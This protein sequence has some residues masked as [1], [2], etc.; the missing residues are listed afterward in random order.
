MIRF[1][2]EI[3]IEASASTIWNVM[4][5]VE[6]WNEWTPT[7]TR[8]QKINGNGFVIGTRLLI[9]QPKLPKAIWKVVEVNPGAGF[10]M[11]KGNPFLQVVAGHV[12]KESQRGTLVTLSLEFAGLFAKPVAKKYK[13]MME[14]YLATEAA[15]LR[16]AS[17]GL[18]LR[19]AKSRGKQKI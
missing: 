3:E 13:D 17:E 9:E 11:K 2:K 14:G 12:L 8:I 4:C 1:T 5:D 7:I 10:V 19:S 18:L 15:G 16:Q 6:T